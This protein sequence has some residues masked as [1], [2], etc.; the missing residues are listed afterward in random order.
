LVKQIST[1][2]QVT[3]FRK[4]KKQNSRHNAGDNLERTSDFR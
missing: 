4:N 1:E 3:V 2:V